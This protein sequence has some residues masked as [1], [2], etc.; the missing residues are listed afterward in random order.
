MIPHICC[1]L[2]LADA[3]RFST[4]RAMRQGFERQP[5]NDLS[6]LIYLGIGLGL[7]AVVVGVIA[8]VRKRR[9]AANRGTD[10]FMQ[11]LQHL[12]LSAADRRDLR[13]LAARSAFT[14][15][16]AILLAP[17]ALA[18]AVAL[19]EKDGADPALRQRAA[20]LSRKLFDADLPEPV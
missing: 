5:Q 9:R 4:L 10:H 11:G 19:A 18:H 17:R 2:L 1:A 6:W 8:L 15:S 16:A 20:E 7:T 14:P 3:D 12:G 13:A